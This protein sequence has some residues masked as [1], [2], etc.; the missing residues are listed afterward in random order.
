MVE[1][2]GIIG[3]LFIVLAFAQNNEKQIRFFDSLGAFLFVIYGIKI[4]ALSVWLLNGIII[5]IN[6]Y[7]I[8]K[9]RR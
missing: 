3:T 7:K 1:W 9:N 6:I 4:H 8:Y 2:L 5:I